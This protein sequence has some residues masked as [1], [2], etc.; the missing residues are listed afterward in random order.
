MQATLKHL[1]LNYFCLF[2]YFM[3]MKGYCYFVLRASGLGRIFSMRLDS[4][5]DIK[6]V[7]LVGKF[8]IQNVEPHVSPTIEGNNC[9]C[10]TYAHIHTRRKNSFKERAGSKIF[11]DVVLRFFETFE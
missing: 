9:R 6:S 3:L 1:H 5:K 7:K 4:N 10:K 8:F 11:W 2:S